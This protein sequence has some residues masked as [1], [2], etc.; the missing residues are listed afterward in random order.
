[1]GRET[2][3]QSPSLEEFEMR[4]RVLV[5]GIVF[6]FVLTLGVMMSSQGAAFADEGCSNFGHN[7][8]PQTPP[9]GIGVFVSERANAHGDKTWLLLVKGAKAE[10]CP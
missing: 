8:L 4:M 2:Q 10:F 5:L 9:P 3:S 7:I 1:M 6:A